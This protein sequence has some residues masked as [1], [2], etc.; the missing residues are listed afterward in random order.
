M[1]KKWDHKIIIIIIIII[2]SATAERLHEAL[3]VEIL[4]T[5]AQL[6]KKI[7]FEKP[8][9]MNDLEGDTRSLG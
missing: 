1:S 6:Y 8:L 7:A 9:C 5:A 2:I 4:T 3:S